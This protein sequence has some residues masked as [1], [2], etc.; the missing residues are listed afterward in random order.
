MQILIGDYM[1]QAFQHMNIFMV[2]QCYHM[3]DVPI[4]LYLYQGV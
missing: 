1:M 2:E 3:M 4:M